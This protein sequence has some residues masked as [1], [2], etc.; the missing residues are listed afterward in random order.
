MVTTSRSGMLIQCSRTVCFS[1]TKIWWSLLGHVSGFKQFTR[2]CG[3]AI[4]IKLKNDEFQAQ[5]TKHHSLFNWLLFL[6]IYSYVLL[7][8]FYFNFLRTHYLHGHHIKYTVHRFVSL[9]S[10]WLFT[11]KQYVIQ[12]MLL[13]LW[14]T[15]VTNFTHLASMVH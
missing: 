9:P 2:D 5:L 7:L 14:S 15:S 11:C 1:L 12:N 10:L 3:Y 6:Y 13:H 8:L 4:N